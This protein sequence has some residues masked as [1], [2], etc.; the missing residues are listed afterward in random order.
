[1]KTERDIGIDGFNENS[2][3]GP[4]GIPV[5]GLKKNNYVYRKNNDVVTDTEPGR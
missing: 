4:D 5:I 3:P 1:M 2:A